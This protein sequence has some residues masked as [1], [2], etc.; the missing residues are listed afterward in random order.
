M[1]IITCFLLSLLLLTCLDASS[2]NR[3][4]KI[5]PINLKK[6]NLWIYPEKIPDTIIETINDSVRVRIY[7]MSSKGQIKFYKYNLRNDTLLRGEY[8]DAKSRSSKYIPFF[9]FGKMS[10]KKIYYYSPSIKH[11]GSVSDVF[12]EQ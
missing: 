7:L 9:K 12:I 8:Q 5:I 10:K 3:K 2:Q 1:K 11:W 6:L 4:E